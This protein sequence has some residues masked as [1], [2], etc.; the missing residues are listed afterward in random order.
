MTSRIRN[1]FLIL[2]AEKEKR[3][4]RRIRNKEIAQVVGVTQHTV[5]RWLKNEVD[6][7]ELPVLEAFCD[8]FA[9]EVGDLLYIEREN[10][11]G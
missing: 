9:C 1:R 7:V 3:E 6:K 2:L 4:G 8:Y 10:A 5:A 11:E